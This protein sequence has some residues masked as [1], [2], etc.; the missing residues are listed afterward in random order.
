MK[1]FL[2]LLP[3]ML[4]AA[5]IHSQQPSNGVEVLER[6]QFGA[7]GELI[8]SADD[9]SSVR[10]LAQSWLIPP[11]TV[12]RA[13]SQDQ[14]VI[15]VQ[16]AV[17]SLKGAA[18]LDMVAT[19][20]Q[21]VADGNILP[22]VG[23]IALASAG[24]DKEGVLAVNYT[25]PRIAN[26]LQKVLPRYA[27]N[28]QQTNFIQK[29]ISGKA[30]QEHIDWCSAQG[31]TPAQVVA[32]VPSNAVTDPS[33]SSKVQPPAPKKTPEAKPASPASEEPTSSTPWSIIIV[34]IVAATGLL[35][36]LVKKRK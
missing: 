36:L 3:M 12:F 31:L 18:Y 14:Q 32:L 23:S 29:L 7:N 6:I 27:D 8:G 10:K 25:D 9:I 11:S 24:S 22:R 28:P 19:V 4:M 13:L 33:Q 16:A 17:E 26:V 34:L 35:W 20:L 1:Q 5:T 15:V 21:G 30:K 2:T